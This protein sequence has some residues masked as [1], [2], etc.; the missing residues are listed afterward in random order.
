M[1]TRKKLEKEYG[2]VFVSPKQI[3]DKKRDIFSLSP[4]LDIALSGGIPNGCWGII[5]GQSKLGKSSL[6]LQ[7]CV[8]AQKV[9]RKCYYFDIEHRLEKKNLEGIPGLEIVDDKL[10]IITSTKGNILVAETVLDIAERILKEEEKVVIVLDS[11][12]ALCSTKEYE[13]KM[14][15]MG[16]HE[17]PRLLAKFTRKLGSIVP[18]QDSTVIIIQHMIANTSGYGSPWQEDGGNKIVYQS[19]FKLRGVSFKKWEEGGKQIGQLN[20]W[21][22]IYSALGQPGGKVESYL[23]FGQGIDKIMENIELACDVGLI[24]KSGAWFELSF[25]DSKEKLQG[26]KKVAD[27]LKENTKEYEILVKKIKEFYML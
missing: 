17:A 12:S 2:K 9:G 7:I 20:N 23:R 25:L 5:S 19:D 11:S 26:Q 8:E 10:E 16:R 4:K 6:A 13:D 27:F 22:I 15:S 21:H 14:T 1:S 3:L 24:E 18:V